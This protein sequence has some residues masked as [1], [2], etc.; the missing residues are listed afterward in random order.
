[1]NKPNETHRP[2][3]Q[4]IPGGNMNGGQNVKTLPPKPPATDKGKP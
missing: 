3:A 2:D 1:M 4:K